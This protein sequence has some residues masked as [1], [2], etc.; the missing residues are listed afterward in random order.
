MTERRDGQEKRTPSPDAKT[1]K[2]VS[3]KLTRYGGIETLT[4]SGS[5]T[6]LDGQNHRTGHEDK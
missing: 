3:P 5:S 6:D 4:Q 1:K 2:Y